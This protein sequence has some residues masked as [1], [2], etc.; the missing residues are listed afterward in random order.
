MKKFLE[1]LAL[2][3]LAAVITL[4]AG[5]CAKEDVPP[6]AAPVAAK[7]VPAPPPPP[8]PPLV[9][10]DALSLSNFRIEKNST[11][12]RVLKGGVSNASTQTITLATA[13]FTLFDKKGRQIGTS[14]ATVDN[15]GPGFAWI[16]EA[17]I[18]EQDVV[19]AKFAGFTVK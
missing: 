12:K 8:P 5:S 14:T 4:T 15:L 6:T 1:S 17:Q 18:L 10:A 11:G 13:T 16:F 3:L 9:S 19:S 2:M 7:Q